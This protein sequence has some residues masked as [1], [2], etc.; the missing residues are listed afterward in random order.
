MKNFKIINNQ[1]WEITK[2]QAEN[3]QDAIRIFK[4]KNNLKKFDN[5]LYSV[6]EPKNKRKNYS[7]KSFSQFEQSLFYNRK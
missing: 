4:Q 7:E 1:T 3:R 2:I 5:N 6:I